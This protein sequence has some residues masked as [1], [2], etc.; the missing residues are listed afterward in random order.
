MGL[1][2]GRIGD[3]QNM[4]RR[5]SFSNRNNGTMSSSNARSYAG[6]SARYSD[7]S[8]N[9]GK[10]TPN[11]PASEGSSET[12]KTHW[13]TLAF[14]DRKLEAEYEKFVFKKNLH[15]WRRNIGMISIVST[16]IHACIMASDY[17]QSA[18]WKTNYADPFRMTLMS[19]N[20][21]PRCP[22]NLFCAPCDPDMIC[23][24]YYLPGDISYWIFGTA[25]PFAVSVA[26]TLVINGDA[27]AKYLHL[28]SITFTVMMSVIAVNLRFLFINPH[29]AYTPGFLC[30]LVI[31][32]CFILLRVRFLYAALGAFLVIVS[33]LI[34]YFVRSNE[35]V[36][37]LP[38]SFYIAFV[39]ICLMSMIATSA[40]YNF[41]NAM[42]R[43]FLSTHNLQ[44]R[45]N[46]LIKQ[47][48]VLQ[49]A[50]GNTAA[51][52]D[53]P[54]EKVVMIVRSLM[55][56]PQI[57]SEQ[58]VSLQQVL[59]LL[60]ST[61]LL[62][63]DFEN[64]VT[65]FMDTEQE[66]WLF[67]EIAPTRRRVRRWSQS[68]GHRRASMTQEMHLKISETIPETSTKNLGTDSVNSSDDD[69]KSGRDPTK[70]RKGLRNA[71]SGL[72]ESTVA[73][74]GEPSLS[75]TKT[76]S[77][78]K[79]VRRPETASGNPIVIIAT[80]VTNQHQ[81]PL[82]LESFESYQSLLASPLAEMT[83]A[84][85]LDFNWS[86]FELNAITEGH[87]LPT[88]A[89]H[90][91]ERENLFKDLKI[92]QE[93]FLNFMLA[94]EKAYHNDLPYH[95]SLHAADVL[96]AM[97]HLSKLEG[98][99]DI[100]SPSDR[101][102]MYMAAIIHDVD[103]PGYTNNFL[104]NSYERRAVLYNDKSILENHHL[105]TAFSLIMEE[106]NN[107]MKDFTKGE[108][109]AT[110]ETVIDMV[111]ATDLS[112]HFSIVSMFK[113]KVAQDFDPFDRRE[114]R[115]LLMKM[116]MKLSDVSNP[117]KEWPIYYK[118]CNLI[119]QEFWRQ[120]DMEKSLNLTVSPY[121]DRDNTNVPSSQIG[122]IDYVIIPLFEAYEKY[123][124]IPHMMMNL[125]RNREHWGYLRSLGLQNLSDVFPP[126][127]S[128][129]PDQQIQAAS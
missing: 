39:A 21:K 55:A 37:L 87:C 85:I 41:E 72:R 119:L 29:N 1:V 124:P 81:M 98:T 20:V 95:N 125:T 110:R 92:S 14:V 66:A 17:I 15:S 38:R 91:F 77:R 126:G 100:A 113:S 51:D 59:R 101:L 65:E 89:L 117:S 4:D 88:L 76:V 19:T 116:M 50:Y 106:E 45:N 3:S 24:D 30:M 73:Q 80:D 2:K 83:F 27:L 23:N 111:L 78:T 96:H 54:L 11:G 7:L 22:L 16:I 9:P 120:G 31:A 129:D 42:R 32:S 69:A 53:S 115:I 103:H 107:F 36:A 102:A 35:A 82:R 49:S 79:S 46:K 6:T 28:I 128:P 90:I 104:I 99:N 61:N 18:A 68:Q 63:P 121:M 57:G 40:T 71:E 74:N 108:F 84:N 112:Q 70:S 105:A 97:Y 86:V 75:R 34:T 109:K 56:D 58:L 127:A 114:D 118:W 64:Q 67:S 43:R 122:F 62:T 94:V 52:L 123:S 13:A 25:I 47:L 60:G 48:K 5:G 10:G 8:N 12:A 33:F 93:K 26:L 44:K